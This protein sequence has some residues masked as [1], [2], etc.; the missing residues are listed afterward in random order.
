V[1]GNLQNVDY[2]CAKKRK[3]S[4]KA[5]DVACNADERL[6]TR[7]KSFIPIMNAL[8]ISTRKEQSC[9]IVLQENLSFS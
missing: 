2:N 1:K 5:N 6:S 4:E 7:A 9:M 8:E 3:K